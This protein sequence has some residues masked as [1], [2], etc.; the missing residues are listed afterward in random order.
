MISNYF[1]IHRI[2]DVKKINKFVKCIVDIH[3]LLKFSPSFFRPNRRTRAQRVFGLSTL[4]RSSVT[5]ILLFERSTASITLWTSF[6]CFSMF[7]DSVDWRTGGKFCSLRKL[8][9]ATTSWFL[10]RTNWLKSASPIVKFCL[11]QNSA[12]LISLLNTFS[13]MYS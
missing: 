12:S 6:S 1:M 11:G 7:L 8:S 5:Q 13:L 2:H 4:Y 9:A 10:R 3:N